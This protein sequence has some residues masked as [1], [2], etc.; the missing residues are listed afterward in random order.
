MNKFKQRK[1][2]ALL[3]LAFLLVLLA[4]A[5]FAFLPGMLDV[6]GRVG[7]REGEYVRWVLAATEGSTRTTD[8]EV[9]AD[10]GVIRS[11]FTHDLLT[12]AQR[13]AFEDA[14][15]GHMDVINNSTLPDA[16][17]LSHAYI[18]DFAGGAGSL[19]GR[20]AQRI[21]WSVVFNGEGTATLYVQAMNFNESLYAEIL[22]ARVVE[23]SNVG[24]VAPVGNRTPS[25]PFAPGVDMGAAT[26]LVGD[27]NTAD[28]GGFQI[29]SQELNQMFTIG[30]NYTDLDGTLDPNRDGANPDSMTDIAYIT[31]HWNGN[32]GAMLDLLNRPLYFWTDAFETD[33]AEPNYGDIIGGFWTRAEWNVANPPDGMT[34]PD[35]F[36]QIM[37]DFDLFMT[38]TETVTTIDPDDPLA[39]PVITTEAIVFSALDPWIGTFILEFDYQVTGAPA[40]P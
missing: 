31:V 2:L 12:S 21:E 18:R 9:I 24:P 3:G 30:G 39:E 37:A 22:N 38:T 36:A 25:F 33:D 7:I 8:A 35:F 6:V 4:G 1:R 16:I 14:Y 32:V 40:G 15:N 11:G 20:A 10:P 26:G 17:Y 29:T 28:W 5:A 27:L 13:T 23:L 19:R 34:H